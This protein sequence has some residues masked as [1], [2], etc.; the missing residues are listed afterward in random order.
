[1]P[2]QPSFIFAGLHDVDFSL[3]N[4]PIDPININEGQIL[5][6]ARMK[7]HEKY[8]YS[9]Y[10]NDVAIAYFDKEFVF[11]GMTYQLIFL[12]LNVSNNTAP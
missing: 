7:V 2:S 8:N 6:M 9:G 1:M 11:S 5:Q 3:L 12:V 10:D 4:L